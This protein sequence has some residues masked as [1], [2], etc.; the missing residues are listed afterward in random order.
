MWFN[1][2]VVS[3]QAFTK[4]IKEMG[5]AA[6]E[7]PSTEDALKLRTWLSNG[8]ESAFGHFF[9]SAKEV[10]GA[11]YHLTDELWVYPH[12]RTCGRRSCDGPGLR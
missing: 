12:W 4:I 10:A 8:M 2:A 11:I 3:S 1:R 5:I 6:N 7:T 9:S